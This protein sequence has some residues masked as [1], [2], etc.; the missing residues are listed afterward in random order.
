M[1]EQTT[2]DTQLWGD[3]W[4]TSKE[5]AKALLNKK[6]EDGQV[7]VVAEKIAI[8]AMGAAIG[9]GRVAL[10]GRP[11]SYGERVEASKDAGRGA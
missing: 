5:A 9:Q 10:T 6:E 8:Q 7:R 4:R 3:I 2:T 11:P 1:A